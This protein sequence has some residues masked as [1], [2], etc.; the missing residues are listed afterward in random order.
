MRAWSRLYLLSVDLRASLI[1]EQAKILLRTEY[2]VSTDA[3]ETHLKEP[4]DNKSHCV[5]DFRPT[6]WSPSTKQAD[7]PSRS[8]KGQR[9]KKSHNASKRQ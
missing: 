8:V 1:T 7:A 2:E 4:G 9:T 5:K 6:G 3:E